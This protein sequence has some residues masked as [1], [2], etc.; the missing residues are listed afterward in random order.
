MLISASVG[1]GSAYNP[2]RT[3]THG[4]HFSLFSY[5]THHRPIHL[6]LLFGPM[7]SRSSRPVRLG[8]LSA[9]PIFPNVPYKCAGREIHVADSRRPPP[10]FPVCDAGAC[11]PNKREREGPILHDI[12]PPQWISPFLF[13]F[14][15]FPFLGRHWPLRINFMI[16]LPS[17]LPIK[18]YK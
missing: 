15:L 17:F 11:H 7:S 1:V 14:F 13:I 16:Y 5:A 8:K 12:P 9:L 10:S 3:H 18:I 2:H 6:S 4:Q